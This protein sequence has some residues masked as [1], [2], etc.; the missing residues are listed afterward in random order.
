[1][2]AKATLT[3]LAQAQYDMTMGYLRAVTPNVA[4]LACR[5]VERCSIDGPE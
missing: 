3:C 4:Y 5:G 1:M 2:G